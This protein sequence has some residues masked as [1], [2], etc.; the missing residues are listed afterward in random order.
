[1]TTKNEI[2]INSSFVNFAVSK[3]RFCH[4]SPYSKDKKKKRSG[5]RIVFFCELFSVKSFL[6]NDY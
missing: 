6:Y 4:K 5:D 1:M 3:I 2:Y